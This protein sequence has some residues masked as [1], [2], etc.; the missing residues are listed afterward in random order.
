MAIF[1]IPDKLANKAYEP[2]PTLL[3]PSIFEYIVFKPRAIF[4]IPVVFEYNDL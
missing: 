1:S 2:I 4:S 3:E